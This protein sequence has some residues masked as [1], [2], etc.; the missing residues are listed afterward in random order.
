ML[1]VQAW[2]RLNDK[3]YS[4]QLDMVSFYNLLIEAGYSRGVAQKAA[5]TRGYQRLQAGHKM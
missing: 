2:E 1:K 5:N 4:G 3:E